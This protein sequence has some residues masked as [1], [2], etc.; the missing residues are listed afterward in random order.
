MSIHLA[1]KAGEIAE[2]I[3]L[4]GDPR[5]AAYI[6][7]HYLEGAHC[8]TETRGMLGFT[9]RYCGKPVSVQG[10]GMGMPSMAIYAEELLREYGVRRLMRIG[11]C[12]AIQ[13]SVQIRDIILAQ[14]ASTDSAMI[15]RWLQ[16]IRLAPQCD[17]ELLRQAAQNA[18]AQGLRYHVGNVF[19]SDSFYDPHD[20]WRLLAQYGT[21]ASEMETAI[22][23]V[24]AAR[25]HASALSMLTVSDHIACGGAC[26]ADERE[27]SFNQ[28][29]ELALSL[30]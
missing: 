4:P 11:T 29:I 21:L 19:T 5:R 28:M 18:E 9:G 6:A 10:T 16:G 14:S 22:L 7:E 26:S 30:V 27:R 17:F 15:D 13:A 20:S 24:L 12:G 2:T 1:A 23:Y 8:Y 25:Y 3:L